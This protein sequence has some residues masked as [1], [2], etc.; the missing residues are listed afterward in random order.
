MLNFLECC[1]C[2]VSTN[3]FVS[4]TFRKSSQVKLKR[5]IHGFDLAEQGALLCCNVW[6]IVH[7]CAC[8]N[9]RYKLVVIVPCRAGNVTAVQAWSLVD[10]INDSWHLS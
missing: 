4:K 8:V 9:K 6:L 2:L 7:T 1:E 5:F 10:G 3:G